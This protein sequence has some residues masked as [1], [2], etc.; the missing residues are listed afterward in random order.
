MQKTVCRKPGLNRLSLALQAHNIC[1]VLWKDDSPKVRRCE[2][3]LMQIQKYQS[4]QWNWSVF[5]ALGLA[6]IGLGAGTKGVSDA[7]DVVATGFLIGGGVVT[8]VGLMYMLPSSNSLE[9]EE[10]GFSYRSGW[11]RV[12]CRWEQCSEFSPWQKEVFG[13]KANELVTFNSENPAAQSKTNIK[14]TGRNAVLPGTYG[15]SAKELADRMNQ[16]RHMQMQRL[17]KPSQTFI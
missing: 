10:D 2:V 4:F 17:Q 14:T 12:F 8:M 1:V 7:M 15:L 3:E 9:I 6:L 16:F 5:V 13:Y 11:Q